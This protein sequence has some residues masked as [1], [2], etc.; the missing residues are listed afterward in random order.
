M[1]L[2]PVSRDALGDMRIKPLASFAF[3]K[4]L[5]M[6]R[7]LAGEA[8]QVALDCPIV[9]LEENG[10]LAPFVM[11][12]LKKGE[13]LFVNEQ[14]QWIASYVP[15][16]LRRYP[17]FMGKASGSDG[18][19]L[20]LLVEE[21]CLSREDGE[22]LFGPKDEEPTGPAARAIRF[23]SE[24]A[25]E[26]AR[27]V[28]LTKALGAQGLFEPLAL[29]VTRGTEEPVK[30]SGVRKISE[31]KLNALSDDVFLEFRRSG[32]LAFAFAHLVSLGQF[33][34]LQALASTRSRPTQPRL[35]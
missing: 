28:A 3:A 11:L 16:L 15:A 34:R 12:G 26:D 25:I 18:E 29:Q 33:A 13:N 24:V 17:F 8:A 6:V 19:A 10:V 22:P 5:A 31:G 21:E 1:A 14:G 4:G 30:L 7:I 2:V 20:S 9:F 35:G 32:A 23:L 27:T